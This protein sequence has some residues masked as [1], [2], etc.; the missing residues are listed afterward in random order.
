MGTDTPI[1]LD[2]NATTPVL[3]AVVEA[4]LPYLRE[5]AGNPSS[6][7][8]FGRR[9]RAAV[10]GAREQVA[11]LLGCASEEIWFTSG[12]T[13]A[14][15]LAIRGATELSTKRGQ[16]VTSDIEHPA[17]SAPCGWLERH[18][19]CV[20]RLQVGRDGRVG[21]KQLTDRI[22]VETTLV[23]VMHSNKGLFTTLDH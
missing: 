1:Y 14:N 9:A 22:G 4:M 8:V 17:T 5:H 7:H 2:Y 18:G 12:G 16:V 3:P 13:E 6:S 10:D 15:N 21:L 20:S 11:A 19:W 23:T